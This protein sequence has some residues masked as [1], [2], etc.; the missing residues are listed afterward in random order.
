[1][2]A[3]NKDPTGFLKLRS[4]AEERKAGTM[5]QDAGLPAFCLAAVP[6]F[7]LLGAFRASGRSGASF[8]FLGS[9]GLAVQSAL[10]DSDRELRSLSFG[11]GKHETT[12]GFGFSVLVGVN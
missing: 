8:V 4:R 1:M 11:A 9:A 5:E 7:L 3:T 12:N 2:G 6:T 10:D